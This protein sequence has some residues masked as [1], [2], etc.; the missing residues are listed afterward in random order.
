MPEYKIMFTE[1][2]HEEIRAESP[3]EEA[4]RGWFRLHHRNLGFKGEV[5]DLRVEEIARPL[6]SGEHTHGP[7]SA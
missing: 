7:V 6:P 1:T 3:T 5:S 2:R 4:V